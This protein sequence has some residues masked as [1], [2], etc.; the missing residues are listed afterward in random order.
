MNNFIVG[1]VTPDMLTHMTYGTY[2]FFG[3]LTTGGAAFIYF[4][5]PETKGLSLEEMDILFGSVGVAGREKE[6]WREVHEE[7]G[8]GALLA[9]AGVTA[10]GHHSSGEAVADEKPVLTETREDKAA[11]MEK[12]V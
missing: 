10:G 3:I 9:R 2:I 12:A 1:Q 5:L 7:V 6:R 4:V 8:L 11:P